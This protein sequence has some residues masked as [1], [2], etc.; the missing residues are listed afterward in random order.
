MSGSKIVPTEYKYSE[1]SQPLCVQAALQDFDA[2][3]EERG[4]YAEQAKPRKNV[5]K[6]NASKPAKA[7]GK[8]T[9]KPKPKPEPRPPQESGSSCAPEALAEESARTK[10]KRKVPEKLPPPALS[11]PLA[12]VAEDPSKPLPD[13]MDIEHFPFPGYVSLNNMYTAVYKNYLKYEGA[14]IEEA[15]KR[16]RLASR[17]MREHKVAVKE[18]LGDHKFSEQ[19]SGKRK[20]AE[21]P[22]EE[23]PAEE[24]PAEE[25]S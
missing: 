4:V 15:R 20:K 9:A 19:K 16:G 13:L 11:E 23:A 8:A 22:A 12:K 25:G 3:N 10:P 17:F 7:K 14:T 18:M 2:D 24:G 1:G 6:K 5:S 21:V